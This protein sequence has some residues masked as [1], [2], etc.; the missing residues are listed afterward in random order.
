MNYYI[1]DLHFG[2]QNCLKFDNRPFDTIEEH[3]A[4]LVA[5]WNSVVT[6][7]DDVYILGDFTLCN[8]EFALK[9]LKQLKGKLHLIIGNH[10]AKMLKN[11]KVRECFCEIT[12]YKE[13]SDCSKHIVLCHYPIC[14]YNRHYYGAYHFYGHVHNGVE[15]G[16]IADTQK[17]L[18]LAFGENACNMYNVGC[19]WLGYTPRTFKEIIKLEKL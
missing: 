16:I 2:H 13:L 8:G 5:N 11:D 7:D 17:Q 15:S 9:I 14:A 12:A 6:D 10:D 18:K 3:D 1:A 19:M 4:A